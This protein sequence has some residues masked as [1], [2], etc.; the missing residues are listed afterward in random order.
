MDMTPL[1]EILEGHHLG[2]EASVLEMEW[3][4][5]DQPEFS[6]TTEPESP[7]RA[8]SPP[9]HGSEGSQSSQDDSLGTVLPANWGV[10]ILTLLSKSRDVPVPVTSAASATRQDAQPASSAQAQSLITLQ[11]PDKASKQREKNKRAQKRHR[12]RQKVSSSYAVS[13]HQSVPCTFSA[14]LVYLYQLCLANAAMC[15]AAVMLQSQ[16]LQCECNGVGKRRRHK[17]ATSYAGSRGE[18]AQ[19]GEDHGRAAGRHLEDSSCC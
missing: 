15:L 1:S 7:K 2:F 18:E 6:A 12:E 11:E 3:G 4:W 5:D 10:H 14:L 8:C 16:Q 17:S 13:D 9:T 19:M